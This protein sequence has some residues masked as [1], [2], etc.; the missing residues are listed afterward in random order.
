MV[1]YLILTNTM[2]MTS[3]VEAEFS[4]GFQPLALSSD[5]L[6]VSGLIYGCFLT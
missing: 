5:T 4:V 3:V 2:M 1:A 6:C